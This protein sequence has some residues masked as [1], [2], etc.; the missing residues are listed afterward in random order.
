LQQYYSKLDDNAVIK[1]LQS[2]V[3]HGAGFGVQANHD[4]D[5]AV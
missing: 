5:F 3:L 1:L 4:V 2:L